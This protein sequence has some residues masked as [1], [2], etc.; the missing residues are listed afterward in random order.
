MKYN[1]LEYIELIFILIIILLIIEI[2]FSIINNTSRCYKINRQKDENKIIE[3]NQKE[4]TVVKGF[5]K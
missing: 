1:V 4:R 2:V 5:K 3:E